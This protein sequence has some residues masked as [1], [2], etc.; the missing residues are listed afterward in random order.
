M[1]LAKRGNRRT[2]YCMDTD[3]LDTDGRTLP[4]TMTCKQQLLTGHP[5]LVHQKNMFLSFDSNMKLL[6][7]QLLPYCLA[8]LVYIRAYRIGLYELSQSVTFF[9]H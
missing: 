6:T 2:G 9:V 5:I 3:G 8:L 4:A 1:M 7:V